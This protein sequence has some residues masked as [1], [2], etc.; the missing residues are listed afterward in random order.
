[1]GSLT[2]TSTASATARVSQRFNKLPGSGLALIRP[3]REPLMRR[4]IRADTPLAGLS[5]FPQKVLVHEV[6]IRPTPG[7]VSSSVTVAM[8]GV[9][10]DQP[11]TIRTPRGWIEWAGFVRLLGDDACLKMG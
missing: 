10:A 4:S 2:G 8:L 5:S 6:C 11:A 1:V 7:R 3:L 9:F